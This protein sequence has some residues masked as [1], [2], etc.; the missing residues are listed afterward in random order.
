MGSLVLS[1]CWSILDKSVFK[2][3]KFLKG[4]Q[5]SRF[6]MGLIR[7]NLIETWCVGS[8]TQTLYLYIC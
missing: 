1:C 4:L 5:L 6:W 2:G 7:G 8:M 3:R